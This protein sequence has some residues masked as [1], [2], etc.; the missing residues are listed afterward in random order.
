VKLFVTGST[1]FVGKAFCAYARAQGHE[2]AGLERPWRLDA[3]P[4]EDIRRFAP[5]ACL[6]T[7]WIATPGEYLNSPLN[8]DY[9]RW[10]REFARGMRDAGARHFVALGT[11]IEYAPSNRKL[12]EE[13]SEVSPRSPYALSKNALRQ[14]LADDS[15]QGGMP[16]AWA[17]LFFPYGPGEHPN[18]LSSALVRQLRQAESVGLKTPASI[19]DYIHI[20]D[21]ARALLKV[22]ESRFEGVINIGVGE[23][24]AVREIAGTIARILAKPGLVSEASPS[25]P[26]DYP[27]VVADVKK[28]ESLGWRPQYDLANGLKTLVDSLQ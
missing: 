16:L 10:S 7:A 8:A 23:G 22:I 27:F 9:L 26:D 5:D 17:R 4:W 28:L 12:C 18:R 14:A 6:H 13:T 3:P 25:Q 21:V 11:C 24:V 2:V 20:D 19:K 15:R 1:G